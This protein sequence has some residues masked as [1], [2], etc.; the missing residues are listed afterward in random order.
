M[1]DAT[2]YI[3]G[4]RMALA[5]T[6]DIPI[7]YVHVINPVVGGGFPAAKDQCGPRAAVCHGSEVTGK[8]VKLVLEREQMF[9]PVGARA[10]TINRIR[11]GASADGK[12]LAMQNDVVMNASVMEDFV[13]HSGGPTKNLYASEANSVSA[14]VVDVNLGVSTFMR[15]PG[16][17]PARLCWRLLWMNWQRS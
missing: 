7:D 14:K 1:Y 10:A 9:G 17:H 16:R 11:L 2:Q 13:E 8:P 4:E 15:A 5:K 3:S 6:L 12:L